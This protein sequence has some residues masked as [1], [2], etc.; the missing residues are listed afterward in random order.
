M[1]RLNDSIGGHRGPLGSLSERQVA[2]VF[3]NLASGVSDLATVGLEDR[4]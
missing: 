3:G 2:A 4:F 1:P